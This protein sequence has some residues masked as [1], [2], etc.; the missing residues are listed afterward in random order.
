MKTIGVL[1]IQGSFSEHIA[2]FG[3]LQTDH[4]QNVQAVEVRSPKDLTEDIHGLVIPGGESTTMGHFL[5]KAQ[6]TSC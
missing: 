1:A 3:R 2:A 6:C 5:K 4:G